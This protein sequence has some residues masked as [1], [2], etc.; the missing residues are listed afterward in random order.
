MER[1]FYNDDF[2]RLIRQKAD[3]YKMY[4]S[5]QVWKGVYK[6]LHGRKRWR[7][8]GLAI[9]LLGIGIYTTNW[10]LSDRPAG[11][12]AKNIQPALKAGSTG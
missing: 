5:D 8:A 9:L 3:Q 4:P 1:N 7:W 11:K 10:Y 6:S 2:E 12:I